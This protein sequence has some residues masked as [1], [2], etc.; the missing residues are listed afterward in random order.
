MN[1]K[2]LGFGI[3]SMRAESNYITSHIIEELLDVSHRFTTN[4]HGIY[5][6]LYNEIK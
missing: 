6:E 2:Q 1:I 3:T 4:I 5:W